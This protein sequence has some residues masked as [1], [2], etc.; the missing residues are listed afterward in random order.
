MQQLASQVQT[1]PDEV[2]Q[3]HRKTCSLDEVFG[4]SG[5]HHPQQ[6]LLFCAAAECCPQ[7]TEFW[8]ISLPLAIKMLPTNFL[9]TH[10]CTE[11]TC[12]PMQK[13]PQHVHTDKPLCLVYGS[14]DSWVQQQALPWLDACFESCML[15]M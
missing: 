10:L 1:D 9:L 4:H 2:F 8:L 6:Q 7:L 15:T 11:T 13:S 12:S 3:Q 14:T 5:Q